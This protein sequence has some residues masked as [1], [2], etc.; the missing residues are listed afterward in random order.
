M[1]VLLRT[2]CVCCV[3]CAVWCAYTVCVWKVPTY[4]SRKPLSKE[5]ACAGG[6][7]V[8]AKSV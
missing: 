4:K 6:D 8:R 1:H 3:V 7:G 5:G 2:E